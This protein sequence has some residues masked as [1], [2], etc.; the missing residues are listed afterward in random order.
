MQK[1]HK[2]KARGSPSNSMIPV[3]VAD[4]GRLVSNISELLEQAR[5]AALRSVNAVLAAAYWEIGRRIVEYEQSGA[6][7]AEYGEALIER[8]AKD[9]T[10]LHGRGFSKQG[11]YKMRGFY[12]GWRIFP[13][14]SGRLISFGS[15]TRGIGL[16]CCFTIAACDALS[17]SISRR[18]H[19][20]TQTQAK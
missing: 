7:R 3:S 10:K 15:A 4:Y 17:W 2:R 8:L 16:T 11:L 6:T 14:P 19:S 12:L 18:G 5:N 9:L 1:R 13:T 20:R